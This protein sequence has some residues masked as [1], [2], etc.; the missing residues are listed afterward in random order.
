MS[1]EFLTDFEQPVVENFRSKK[2]LKKYDRLQSISNELQFTGYCR[3]ATSGDNQD[4]ADVMFRDLCSV[5]FSTT[6][7]VLKTMPWGL[8][9]DYCV[10]LKILALRSLYGWNIS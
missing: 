2:V 3:S 8:S 5:L 1:E 10:L 7:P 4:D 9:F 6:S